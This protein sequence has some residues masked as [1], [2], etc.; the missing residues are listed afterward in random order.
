VFF[1][2]VYL[3]ESIKCDGND[4]SSVQFLK[5]ALVSKARKMPFVRETI[6]RSWLDVKDEIQNT[7]TVV[8]ALEKRL[9]L[10]R[11]DLMTHLRGA[12]KL[13]VLFSD[14]VQPQV[15]KEFAFGRISVF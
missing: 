13:K 2:G 11:Q 5:E 6:L 10:S 12:E 14:A 8:W 15:E 3:V 4:G 7:F 9:I 1:G